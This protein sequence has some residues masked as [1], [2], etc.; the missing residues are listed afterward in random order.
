[1]H[2]KDLQDKLGQWRSLKVSLLLTL[3]VQLSSFLQT[4]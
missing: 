2:P 3:L 1:M 4:L